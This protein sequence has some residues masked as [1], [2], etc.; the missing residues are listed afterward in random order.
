MYDRDNT[1]SITCRTLK[2]LL[3]GLGDNVN[4]EEVQEVLKAMDEDGNGTIDF[5]EFLLYMLQKI[6]TQSLTEDIIQ[7]FSIF[8]RDST[9][10]ITPIQLR[11]IT[12]DHLPRNVVDQF[13]EIADVQGQG[14]INY[15]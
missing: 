8:D 1:G 11:L 3:R 2:F 10:Y 15:K 9:G 13:I 14:Q 12:Q 4:Q 5:R 6:N 7:I